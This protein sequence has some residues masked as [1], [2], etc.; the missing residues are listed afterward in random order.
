MMD[1]F[2]SD[3]RVKT[4]FFF[5]FVFFLGRIIFSYVTPNVLTLLGLH[6][7]C[8]GQVLGISVGNISQYVQK[9]YSSAVAC[10]NDHD[11][12]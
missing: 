10:C 11:V 5:C 6:P 1:P 3:K 9:G 7:H 4:L 12:Q 8:L 2:R